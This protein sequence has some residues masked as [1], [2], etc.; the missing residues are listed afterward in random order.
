MK[1]VSGRSSHDV[2]VSLKCL[3]FS[4]HLNSLKS[5]FIVENSYTGWFWSIDPGLSNGCGKESTA[6]FIF[7]IKT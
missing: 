3:D 2:D 5:E 4:S 1:I 6:S 7:L